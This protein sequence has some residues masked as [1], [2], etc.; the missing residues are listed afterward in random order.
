MNTRMDLNFSS[1]YMKYA[2]H[3][4]KMWRVV[5]GEKEGQDVFDIELVDPT[6]RQPFREKQR[7]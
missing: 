7:N 4:G 6:F 3:L 2:D 1:L 5:V